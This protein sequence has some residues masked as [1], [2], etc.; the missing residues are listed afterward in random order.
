[1]EGKARSLRLLQG[2]ASVMV[3]HVEETGSGEINP[4]GGA[5]HHPWSKATC[6]SEK[7]SHVRFHVLILPPSVRAREPV[8]VL[9]CRRFP[10][11]R[12]LGRS[13]CPAACI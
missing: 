9:A 5:C 1:M 10:G 3:M 2:L 4:G 13:C 8:F 12:K 6:F 11:C 7:A